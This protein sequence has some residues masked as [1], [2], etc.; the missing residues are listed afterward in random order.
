MS[1][2][3]SP[4]FTSDGHAPPGL[5]VKVLAVDDEPDM[6]ENVARILRRSAY[7]C[8]TAGSGQAALAVLARD[9]PDLILTDLR[10]PGMDGLALLRAVKQFSPP[11]PVVVF[12]ACASDATAH[13]ALAAGAAAFLAKPFTGAQL[14]ETVRMLLDHRPG[15][16]PSQTA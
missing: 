4:S 14:M 11:T 6:L 1:A 10:M 7:Q 3:H 9:R 2:M 5:S 16:G 12:T 8:V 15:A 13:E